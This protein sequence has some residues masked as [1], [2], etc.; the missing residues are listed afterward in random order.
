MTE[1]SKMFPFVPKKVQKMPKG[2]QRM[3]KTV[4]FSQMVSFLT[5]ASL[6]TASNAPTPSVQSVQFSP[7][8]AAPPADSAAEWPFSEREMAQ[9]AIQEVIQLQKEKRQK[10][11]KERDAGQHK[12][13]KIWPYSLYEQQMNKIFGER[14]RGTSEEKER[15]LK[16]H[17]PVVIHLPAY[18]GTAE[19]RGGETTQRQNIKSAFERTEL[20]Q[21][22][23]PIRAQSHRWHGGEKEKGRNKVANRPRA[24][25]AEHSL[26]TRPQSMFVPFHRP[27]Q[28]R[29]IEPI[30]SK[31]AH[32]R[33]QL[34]EQQQM[35]IKRITSADAY[36]EEESGKRLAPPAHSAFV[37][38]TALSPSSAS[39]V[40]LASV[41]TQ[42]VSP[43]SAQSSAP[44]VGSPF[45]LLGAQSVPNAAAIQPN[46]LFSQ[47]PNPL[48]I[49]SQGSTLEHITNLARNLIQMSN[50]KS[51]LFSSLSKAIA[52]PASSADGGASKLTSTA[53]QS[54]AK[55][56][57][58]V[59]AQG[60]K[61][62]VVGAIGGGGEAVRALFSSNGTTETEERQKEQQTNGT[63]SSDLLSD[64]PAEQR[65]LLEAAMKNGELDLAQTA[66]A[67]SGEKAKADEASKGR[68]KLVN[69]ESRL[70][71]WIQQNRPRPGTEQKQK[72][73]K[74]ATNGE[75]TAE[76]GGAE[77]IPYFG[78]YCGH[79]VEQA[80]LSR[81]HNVAGAVWAI[82]ERR[83]LISKFNFQPFERFENVTFWA[84]PAKPTGTSQDFF[85]S[86]NGIFLS[87]E[88]LNT[89]TFAHWPV[90]KIPANPR[91]QILP[92][93]GK[94][95]YGTNNT[96]E[97]G[98]TA[99]EEEEEEK[100]TGTNRIGTRGRREKRNLYSEL[101]EQMAPEGGT[102]AKGRTA[103]ANSA[104][105]AKSDSSAAGG[106]GTAIVPIRFDGMPQNFHLSLGGA[107]KRNEQQQ[108][109][110]E[111]SDKFNGLAIDPPA[112]AVPLGEECHWTSLGWHGGTQPLLITLP[113]SR[114]IKTLNWLSVWDHSQKQPI[115]LVLLPSAA[116]GAAFQSPSS[117]QLRPLP[118]PNASIGKRIQSGP[119]RV[120][121]T[122]TIE[123]TEFSLNTEGMPFWFMVGKEIVPNRNGQIVPVF[124]RK[125]HTFD[126]DSLRD[127]HNETVTLR[128]SDPFDMKDVFW[129]SVYSI[130]RS[131]SLAH[132]YIPYNDMQLP[133]D[134]LALSTPQ[135]AWSEPSP[136]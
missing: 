76:N 103:E 124:D 14:K 7:N 134:L 59:A 106:G 23:K 86:E 11:A 10:G 128:L 58:K 93:K 102:A 8:Y 132:I 91:A 35:F 71:E 73:G 82:D 123:L 16:T 84:G 42:F 13:T 44:L 55:S 45:D 88:K 3:P 133:P 54:I 74:R 22:A 113:D 90:Q 40:P 96:T 69:A 104:A 105:P 127:F 36:E 101:Y 111:K 56:V 87:P 108:K 27:S 115:A 18:R 135:C 65:I 12:N 75:K 2:G 121:D 37:S 70:M 126:C 26:I 100:E 119:I 48:Q 78:K 125:S 116:S 80:N 15:L 89:N 136:G 98:K 109:G 64:L 32:K 118:A 110:E 21:K 120:L 34:K 9:L 28:L 107:P 49:L 92:I 130:P 95:Y 72:D 99:E 60:E 5:I 129:F 1:S 83:L 63:S 112:E 62:A 43:L 81:Q 39:S 6:V 51:D 38:G 122:K 46:A 131:Q 57:S 77:K 4:R 67:F 30:N 61:T 31:T 66:K 117:V 25:S 50:G 17:T 114:L 79:F 29:P 20:A 41:P 47:L 19:A 97:K 52:S 24:S 33:Q 85:P 53:V 68:T 94:I